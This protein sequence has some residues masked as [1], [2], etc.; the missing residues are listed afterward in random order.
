[1]HKQ[2]E[3]QEWGSLRMAKSQSKIF[4][5]NLCFIPK[6][7]L[8]T[9]L[10]QTSE[11]DSKISLLWHQYD[12]HNDLRLQVKTARAFSAQLA[13]KEPEWYKANVAAVD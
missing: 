6:S 11:F 13:T 1:M 3:I 7:K 4:Q 10:L 12:N 9:R 2:Q 8:V 5:Y